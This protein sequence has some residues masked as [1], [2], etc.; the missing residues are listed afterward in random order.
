[1]VEQES[2]LNG[3]PRIARRAAGLPL[4][5]TAAGRRFLRQVLIAA[6]RTV[7]AS[8]AL[9][10]F[11]EP[12]R[13]D[14]V[15]LTP[16]IERRTD[17]RPED[18][19]QP[20][21]VRA[22][23]QLGIPTAACIA[24]WDH[25]TL[26]S[27]ICPQPDRVFVWNETQRREAHD[28][29]GFSSARVVVTGAQCY[30]EWFSWAPRP[31][32]E[33]CSRVGLD[34]ERPYVLYTCLV[35]SRKGPSEVE[36]VLRWLD[37]LR[38]D[39]DPLLARTGVLVRPHPG[40][41]ENWQDLDTS[42]YEN[43][44]VFPRQHGFPTDLEAKSDYFDSIY[45]SGAVVGLNT[46][47]MLEAAV[48]GRPVLTVLEPEFEQY[49]MGRP[50][51]RYLRDVAGGLVRAANGLDEHVTHLRR[52][53]R[54][55]GA[56]KGAGREFVREFLRPHGLDVEATPIFVDEVERLASCT[57]AFPRVAAGFGPALIGWRRPIGPRARP[58]RS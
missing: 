55:D 28:L 46:S 1:M 23:R 50:H 43:V 11:L 35:S 13:P 56:E 44:V 5:R 20:E 17:P 54:P 7:P 3:V 31:H 32:A 36:L 12:R 21:L 8:T 38:G 16:Y 51:F 10:R 57:P 49:Q 40:R 6:D 42:R 29:H 2:R 18:A 37:A 27:S 41:T 25:L 30:D 22:A 47:A 33:F 15:L 26:K 14:I 34:P 24:S 4:L 39:S 48:I 53:L 58:G 45:H 9:V 52:A 19:V